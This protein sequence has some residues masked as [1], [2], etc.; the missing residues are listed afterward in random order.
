MVEVDA[1]T[2]EARNLIDEK[3]EHVH[4]DGPRR[5]RRPEA[6]STG[7]T[8][9]DEIIYASERDGWRHL[10]LI[11]AKKG[12]IK[13]PITRGRVRRPR[14]RPH[15]RGQAAGLVPRR[16]Q[17][18]RAR[19]R[20]SSTT[21]ASTSTAR[22]LVAL[23]EGNGNHSVQFSP[24]RTYLIDTYSR[25]DMPPVHELRRS[26]RRH[27]GLQARGGRHLGLEGDAAG[28]RPRSSSPRGAT[29]RPTSGASSAGPRTS[30]RAG[31]TR[32]SSRSTPGRKA[33]SCPRRSA[34]AGRFASADRTS[35]SSSCRSTAWARRTARRRSTTSAGTTSRTPASPTASSGTRPSA[36]KYPYY[37]LSR[38]GI[39]GVSAGGQNAAGG[40]A[41]PPRVLQGRR[42]GL[43]LPRQPHGQGL[44]ERAVDGLPR[45][46]LVR[47]VLEH[48]QRP[49]AARQAAADRGRD[50]HQRAA[51][52]DAAPGRRA[53]P[54]GQGLRP[55]W[56]CPTPTTA[57]EAPYGHAADA[58]LLR[59]PPARAEPP[60]RNAAAVSAAAGA[61]PCRRRRT[62]GLRCHAARFVLR[63]R[64]ADATAMRPGDSTRSTSRSTA[65]P[66]W[67]RATSPTRP[68]CARARSSVTCSPA[69]PTS[70][71]RWSRRT[72]T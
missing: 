55:A 60:D 1:H 27:A 33:R 5:E 61:A 22:G 36:A 10:Y 38:V 58:G 65:C 56:S 23:T 8:R 31:S 68:S 12:E 13:N 9:P 45:R 44:V 47:R 57:W 71:G 54:G 42:R 3:S 35:A 20:T 11:D 41:V 37:D 48:R 30:T 19:T 72:C 52:I 15:R 40:A 7:S 59:P 53:D 51:R 14:H 70:S 69:V 50:G 62:I 39:Y 49:P 17:E 46:A 32:S 2:G 18:S 34:R 29:A 16:R 67:P 43:R 66:S 24:D 26:F 4:L 25:V 63:D 6:A 64:S 28:S 21:T